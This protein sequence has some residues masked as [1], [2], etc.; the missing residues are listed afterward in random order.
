MS[1]NLLKD[2]TTEKQLFQADYY[3]AFADEFDTRCHR[4]NSNHVYKIEQIADTFFRHLNPDKQNYDFMELGT[5][6]GIH[7]YHF[8]KNYGAKINSFMLT[9]ISEKMLQQANN[10]LSEFSN[11]TSYSVMPAEKFVTQKKFD[12][13]FVSGSMHHFANPLVALAEMKKH[14]KPEGLVV[15]CEPVV[16]N[17]VNFYK[18]LREIRAEHGQFKTQ[19]KTVRRHMHKLGYHI[20]TDRVLHYRAGSSTLRRVIPYEKMENFQLLNM[21]AV[22][23]LLGASIEAK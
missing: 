20:V 19:R 13:I 8:L 1:Q 14:L 15:V 4:E 22:M 2:K 17:P 23:F 11:K 21:M 10:R 5:G 12:G 6:T 3:N 9:D 7:A 16:W 18:A